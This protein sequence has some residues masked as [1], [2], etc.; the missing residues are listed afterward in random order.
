[1]VLLSI[2][3]SLYK[4]FWACP[5]PVNLVSGRC[6]SRDRRGTT[7]L[8]FAIIGPVFLLLVLTMMDAMWLLAVE[9]ALIDGGQEAARL[10]SLGTLPVTGTREASIQSFVIT[11][12]AGMLDAT[13][14]TITM[15]TYGGGRAADY[16]HRLS[17]TTKTAGAGS[18]RQ[19]VEYQLSYVQPLLTPFAMAA[20]GG[21]TSFTHST[22]IVVQNEPF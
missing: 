3:K 21:Q 9:M 13:K 2:I 20:M 15:Q 4:G 16:A 12:E 18:G 14:L 11:R 17:N 8:E 22:T 5:D 6:L 7:L 1:M 10:G 19:L